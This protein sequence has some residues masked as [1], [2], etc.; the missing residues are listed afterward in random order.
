MPYKTTSENVL[1]NL[2]IDDIGA[3]KVVY[4]DQNGCI[5]NPS[6]V[7]VIS[8]A[9]PLEVQVVLFPNPSKG[10]FVLRV[11][12]EPSGGYYTIKVLNNNGKPVHQVRATPSRPY[13][14]IEV[15][16]PMIANGIYRVLVIDD[17]GKLVQTKTIMCNR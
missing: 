13:E 9:K 11:S 3:Y 17:K 14:A 15:D 4:E 12:K 7:V 10:K 16:L 5:S 1:N 8:A 2:K 6:T